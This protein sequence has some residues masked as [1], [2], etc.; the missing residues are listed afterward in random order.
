MYKLFI[1]SHYKLCISF[2]GDKAIESEDDSEKEQDTNEVVEKGLE[3]L[4]LDLPFLKGIA[5]EDLA[6][7]LT[8]EGQ[9]DLNDAPGIEVVSILELIHLSSSHLY[10]GY[11]Q[12]KHLANVCH[13][14]ERKQYPYKKGKLVKLA[15]KNFKRE[16]WRYESEAFGFK[17]RWRVRL[18]RLLSIF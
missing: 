11:D 10:G 15:W 1:N 3:T 14:I 16:R 4:G 12:E 9:L 2:Q 6:G 8:P 18:K 5:G 17:L 7:H 13:A